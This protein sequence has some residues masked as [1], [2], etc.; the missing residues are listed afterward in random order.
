MEWNPAQPIRSTCGRPTRALFPLALALALICLAPRPGAGQYPRWEATLWAGYTATAA[1]GT[2]S[3]A[4][5]ESA[6]EAGVGLRLVELAIWY[7]PELRFWVQYDNGLT[8]D[9]SLLRNQRLGAPSLYGGG[10]YHWGG[11]YTTRL[12]G[13]WREVAGVGQTLVRGEQVAFLSRPLALRVGGWAAT[14]GGERT[15]LLL[16]G[17]LTWIV[18]KHLHIDPT[19]FYSP[20]QEGAGSGQSRA[21]LFAEFQTTEGWKVGLG[22]AGGVTSQ[23]AEG[24]DRVLDGFLHLAAPVTGGHEARLLL[25]REEIGDRHAL[26]SLSVGLTLRPGGK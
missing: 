6:T 7:S 1:P 4:G 23:G 16:H 13:G 2:E 22:A 20:G 3:G 5:T 24:R 14:G 18:S 17:G 21:L 10:L 19:L 11:R 9:N 25:R 8:L 12:E 26:T 15:E